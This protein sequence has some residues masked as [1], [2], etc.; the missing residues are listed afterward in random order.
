MGTTGF[1]DP[2]RAITDHCGILVT[3][4]SCVRLHR[5]HDSLILH[6]PPLLSLRLS[7]DVHCYCK[8]MENNI[9]MNGAEEN[10]IHRK[11]DVQTVDGWLTFAKYTCRQST[12]MHKSRCTLQY[13]H[14]NTNAKDTSEIYKTEFTD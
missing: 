7:L 5:N 13:A 4:A 14:T 12:H 11:H 9:C 10:V 2:G 1:R 6:L 3:E 8:F